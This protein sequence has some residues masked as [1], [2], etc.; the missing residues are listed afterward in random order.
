MKCFSSP[1]TILRLGPLS[2]VAMAVFADQ[3]AIAAGLDGGMGLCEGS[4]LL[5]Y[6]ALAGAFIAA[7]AIAVAFWEKARRLAK[8]LAHARA[9]LETLAEIDIRFRAL[10]CLEPVCCV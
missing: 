1:T 9:R 8:R 6:S 5:T 7:A 10:G 4:N 3:P 2:A